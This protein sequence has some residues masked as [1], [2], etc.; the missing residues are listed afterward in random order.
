MLNNRLVKGIHM[1]QIP[2]HATS[3]W[4]CDL[5]VNWTSDRLCRTYFAM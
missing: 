2:C 5:V 4:V 3:T 1:D